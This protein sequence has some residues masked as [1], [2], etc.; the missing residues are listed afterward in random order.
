MGFVSTATALRCLSIFH[1]TLA[2]YFLT[3]PVRVADQNAVFILG[4]AMGIPHSLS[5]TLPSASTAVIGL[6]L[7]FIGLTDLSSTGL[8]ED[9]A[10]YFWSSQA[11]IRLLF[12][13]GITGYAYLFSQ[14]SNV[15]ADDDDVDL[16]NDASGAAG[17]NAKNSVV[18]AWGFFELVVWFY[19]FI[20]LREERTA[21]AAKLA[22]RKQAEEER[23]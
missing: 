1:L 20:T 22:E 12:F 4:E 18:F 13:F 21:L 17:E 11:P 16:V 9:M 10:N 23:L 3:S 14:W 8:P 7:A 5:L 6:L 19:I 15:A 2:Y